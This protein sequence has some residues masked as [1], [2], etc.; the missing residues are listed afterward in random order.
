MG[1][2]ITPDRKYD[3]F[4]GVNLRD[5]PVNLKP[6]DLLDSENVFPIADGSMA[7]RLGQVPYNA[8]SYGADRIRSLYRFYKQ[9]GTRISLVTYGTKIFRGDDVTGALTELQGSLAN[10]R[11]FSFITWSA[12]DKVYWING[13]QPLRS[14]DGTTVSTVAGS[15]PVGSQIELHDDR[16]WILQDDLVSFSDLN[17][18]NSWPA[19]NALNLSDKKGG[20]GQFLK[21]FGRGLLVAAKDTGLWRFE[22]SPLL[23]GQ[24]T[25]YSDIGC[26]A[27]WTADITPFGIPFLSHD[28]IYVTDGFR[29]DRISG[30]IDP[31]FSG[32]GRFADA[33]GKYY[34][35]RRQYFFSY[36]T[37]L[38]INDQFWAATYIETSKGPAI[39]WNKYTGFKAESF[40]EWDGAGDVGQ[41]YYGRAD[42]G[43]IRWMDI[44]SVDIDQP[45]RCRIEL[46]ND[47]L[48]DETRAK[49][50]RFIFPNW[51][52][53]QPCNYTISY[54]FGKQVVSG[55]L[56]RTAQ[57]SIQWGAGAVVWGAGPVLWL[58]A[59]PMNSEVTSCLN[60]KWGQHVSFT[61]ENTGDGELFKF[62]SAVIK[63]KVKEA[64]HRTL[65][66][67]DS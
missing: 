33:V 38:A 45:Y 7:G 16:M 64:T 22:G 63:T 66:A 13:V 51:E 47:A 12:K 46:P 65:F 57:E 34:K 29:V 21:S 50:P 27:G 6:G 4:F 24:L 36:N 42:T 31:L 2:F 19:A 18:D 3:R 61:F 5:Q 32:T 11:K 17:A 15:P 67:I 44:G 35:R 37:A 60:F 1:Q 58:N 43:Q 26:I 49:Q 56:T 62:H 48:G 23:G 59:G 28:G 53:L 14:Y 40:M 10:D 39:G 20:Q 41:M 25:P 55:S 30:K 9:D 8:V 52:G 54:S